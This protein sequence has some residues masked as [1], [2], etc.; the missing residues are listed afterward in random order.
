MLYIE[1]TNEKIEHT[2]EYVEHTVSIDDHAVLC[3]VFF[4]ILSLFLCSIS[5]TVVG[6][7]KR[8]L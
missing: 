6:F 5:F 3:R 7:W 2:N 4:G 8:A 1:H